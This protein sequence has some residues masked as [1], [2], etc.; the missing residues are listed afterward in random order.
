MLL[1]ITEE[2]LHQTS[3]DINFDVKRLMAYWTDQQVYCRK[4]ETWISQSIHFV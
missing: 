4:I 3:V 1:L 2:G